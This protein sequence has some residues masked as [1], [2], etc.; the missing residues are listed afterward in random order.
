MS[1]SLIQMR[2]FVMF[3]LAL[4][5]LRRLCEYVNLIISV[6]MELSAFEDIVNSLVKN[7]HHRQVTGLSLFCKALH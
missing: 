7:A 4:I 6:I 2:C 5:R 3:T 1:N